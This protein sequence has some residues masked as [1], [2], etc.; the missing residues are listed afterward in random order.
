MLFKFKT[1]LGILGHP[2]YQPLHIFVQNSN[3]FSS[4]NLKLEKGKGIVQ[5]FLFL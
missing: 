4:T 1:A 5:W 3:E 2:E